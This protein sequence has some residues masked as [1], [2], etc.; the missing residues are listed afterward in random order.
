MCLRKT[1]GHNMQAFVGAA[2]DPGHSSTGEGKLPIVCMVASDWTALRVFRRITWEIVSRCS[3]GKQITQEA[4]AI[5]KARDDGS[6][7]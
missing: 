4:T 6:V 2:E 7:N 5:L 3:R 1:H